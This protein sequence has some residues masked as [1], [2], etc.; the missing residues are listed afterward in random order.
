MAETQDPVAALEA[1]DIPTRAAGARDLGLA[2]E[3]AH[4]TRLLQLAV[5]DVSPG[6]RLAAAAAA[7]DILSRHRLP[8]RAGAISDGN[9]DAWLRAVA[10]VDPGVN[11][12]LFQVCGTLGTPAAVARLVVALR[13]PRADVRTGACVGLWRLLA[14]AAANG[15]AALEATVAGLFE[16]ARVKVDTRAEIARICANVGWGV[17]L[18]P[19]RALAASTQK[20]VAAT[21]S[22]AVQRL[23]WPPRSEG[24]WTDL[25]LDC[26]AVDPAATPGG[27]VA[28]VDSRT[29]VVV[30]GQAR[31][32]ELAGPV[33]RL[34]AK[35][36]GATQAGPVL[37]VGA[38]TLW[39]ADG[40]EIAAF[41]DRL[42]EL[43]EADLLALVDPFLPESAAAVRLRGVARLKEGDAAGAAE[44]LAS[45][46][47]MK[48]VPADTWWWLAE[49]LH[50]LGRDDE[51]RPHLE[52]FLAKAPKKG[53]HVAEAKKRLGS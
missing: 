5:G 31:K 43:G 2:G 15:D 29:A 51:A 27:W 16:D 39:P 41:G 26:G 42:L 10:S 11:T 49:A 13:D 28:V 35:R 53:P 44:I 47:A 9:R 48:K 52:K 24:V 12:G 4:V 36:P 8:P 32:E 22:E 30:D 25:G 18:E 17:A 1:K 46:V 23:E 33:R 38:R 45:A 3:P 37:Q 34:W 40:D 19:A 6:V 20:T 14:S 21:A 7:A 50:R